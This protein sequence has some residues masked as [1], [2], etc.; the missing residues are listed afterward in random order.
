VRDVVGGCQ[1]YVSNY[2]GTRVATH[3]LADGD[4]RDGLRAD[5]MEA[6]T[7][8]RLDG[9]KPVSASRQHHSPAEILEAWLPYILL[10]IFALS[11]LSGMTRSIRRNSTGSRC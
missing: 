4:R 11:M 10:V 6:E 9:D 5:V 7:I 8:F 3:E 2:M 1:F